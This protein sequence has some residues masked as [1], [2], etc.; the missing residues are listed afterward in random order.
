MWRRY[1]I[2][3]RI[4]SLA[5]IF[6]V[7]ALQLNQNFAQNAICKLVNEKAVQSSDPRIIAI[8]DL[9]GMFA[10]FKKILQQAGISSAD[11]PC[12]WSKPSSPS[13]RPT[14]LVQLGDLVDR[15]VESLECLRCLE[16]LQKTVP[17][18]SK[19][20]RLIGNHDIWWMEGNF[21]YTEE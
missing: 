6:L 19:V 10:S 18:G 16:S 13:A 1:G 9:H 20:V 12:V 17:A 21:D 5:F 8:G 7:I 4:M 2:C 15:G 3:S 11:D 14:V